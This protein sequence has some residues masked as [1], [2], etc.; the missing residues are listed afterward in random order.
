[1]SPFHSFALWHSQGAP[2]PFLKSV[3]LLMLMPSGR[4]LGSSPAALNTP[5]HFTLSCL[6]TSGAVSQ[7]VISD[8]AHVCKNLGHGALFCGDGGISS[9]P[10]PEGMHITG[11]GRGGALGRAAETTEKS[12]SGRAVL[13]LPN[14]QKYPRGVCNYFFAIFAIFHLPETAPRLGLR[15][16][17]RRRGFSV[18]TRRTMTRHFCNLLI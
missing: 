10:I 3:P 2:S 14:T 12:P 17:R 15:H 16:I 4:P 8:I 5:C 11:T 1:M 13:C 6:R 7:A 18:F 9:P